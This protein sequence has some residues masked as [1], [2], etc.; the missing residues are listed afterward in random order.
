MAGAPRSAAAPSGRAVQVDPMKP[1]LKVP[2][3]K[4]LKPEH[5]I[6]L[7]DFAVNVNLRRYT[8]APVPAYPKKII[9]KNPKERRAAAA[10]T[11]AAA[12]AA[13]GDGSDDDDDIHNNDA[14][15]VQ[16]TADF[17]TDILVRV[18]DTG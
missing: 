3:A 10:A 5:G 2:G 15:R 7:S 8:P 11:A 4:L 12:A 18:L 17:G 16:S 1:T 9:A 13:D 14:K 6:L